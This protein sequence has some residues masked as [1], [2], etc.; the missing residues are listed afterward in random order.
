M[1]RTYHTSHSIYLI[2]A[3]EHNHVSKSVYEGR[4]NK[5]HVRIRVKSTGRSIYGA[6]DDYEHT[7]FRLIHTII[8][9]NH[10][11]HTPNSAKTHTKLCWRPTGKRSGGL[12][13]R[14]RP[15]SWTGL[16]SLFSQFASATL[17]TFIFVVVKL[18]KSQMAWP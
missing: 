4:S 8:T 3:P 13:A 16:R 6:R 5:Q 7:E 12:P 15:L 17:K 11:S 14:P 9:P 18:L 1:P 2:R 10:V